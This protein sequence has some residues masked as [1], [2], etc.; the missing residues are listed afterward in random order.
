[1]EHIFWSMKRVK[2]LKIKSQGISRNVIEYPRIFGPG[3]FD[4]RIFGP[5]IFGP[6]M[7]DPWIF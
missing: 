4:P 7:F 2:N 1:M 6:G 5:G 3:M